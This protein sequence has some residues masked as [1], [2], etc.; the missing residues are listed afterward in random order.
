MTANATTQPPDLAIVICTYHREALLAAC[1]ESVMAQSR[2]AGLD[3]QVLV[4]DNSD[5]GIAAETTF[6]AAAASP[7]PVRWLEAHP[8]NISIARNAAVAATNA[9]YIAFVDDDQTLRP[10]W[11]DAVAKAIAE[12]PHDVFFGAVEPQFEAPERSTALVRQ[13]FSRR[14]D[15]PAGHDLIA[16]GPGK[17]PGIALA[18]CNSV[19]R[20]AAMAARTARGES[21]PF[22]PAFGL[23]GGEDYDLICRMQS[24]GCRFGWL[25]DARACEFVPATRCDE[26]YLRDR[27]FAGGQAFAAALANASARPVLS[28]WVVRARALV[29]GA[30]VILQWP[31]HLL[32]GR[33]AAADH[34]YIWA[35]VRGKLSLREI[36]PIYRR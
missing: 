22:D 9:R 24:A 6:A 21:G 17:T 11:L 36:Y 3:I 1:L 28:R 27:F 25:P 32:R 10:G 30:I 18:T 33:E 2:P 16:M 23:G 4:V 35:G 14:L 12:F 26:A 31:L 7:L 15:Q 5:N 29:Q 13:L 34:A 19:F 8:A 20:R